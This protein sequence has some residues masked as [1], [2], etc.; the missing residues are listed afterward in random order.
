ML[1]NKRKKTGQAFE[2]RVYQRGRWLRLVLVWSIL[3]LSSGVP[4]G[5]SSLHAAARRVDA[6]KANSQ[7]AVQAIT[8]N[9]SPARKGMIWRAE[10]KWAIPDGYNWTGIESDLQ[11]MQNAGA[12]WVRIAFWQDK[13]F[14]YYDRLLPLIAQYNIQ[15]LGNI[16]KTDPSKELGTPAQQE[17]YRTWLS[18]VVTRYQ[19]RVRYWE[20][21]NETNIP[22]GWNICLDTTCQNSDPAAYSQAVEDY[23]QLLRIAH[24]T[25]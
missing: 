25:I 5:H 17:A 8:G 3:L 15:I 9:Q 22:S 2:R 10:D 14:S 11:D 16:R 7:A 20:V 23:V 19:G 6:G 24:N 12:K 18:R 13:P 21:E 4:V 1:L